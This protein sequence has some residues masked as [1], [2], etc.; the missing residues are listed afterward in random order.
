MNHDN[1]TD[2][3]SELLDG[4]VK[5]TVTAVSW[6]EQPDQIQELLARKAELEGN[7]S[8]TNDQQLAINGALDEIN[9]SLSDLGYTE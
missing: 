3:Q 4:W 5:T 2:T 6:H 9:Q 7:L 8:T 1:T